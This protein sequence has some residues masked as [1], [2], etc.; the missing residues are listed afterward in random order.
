MEGMPLNSSLRVNLFVSALSCGAFFLLMDIWFN[1]EQYC[2]S[3]TNIEQTGWGQGP[4][5]VLRLINKCK[6]PRQ[7]I[8]TFDNFSTSLSL[9]DKL[10][11]D[12]IWGLETRLQAAPLMIKSDLQKKERGAYRQASNGKYIVIS[13]YGNKDV[14][15]TINYLSCEPISSVKCWSKSEIKHTDVT[16]LKL[17]KIYNGIMGG[18]D[19]FD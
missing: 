16:M 8:V 2:A 9:L 17:F 6:L 14:I 11:E 5:V 10:S 3:A 18:V 1:A 13:S 15:I 4:N 7:S 19:L 12:S